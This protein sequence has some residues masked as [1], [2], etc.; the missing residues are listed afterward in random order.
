MAFKQY[1]SPGQ[2]KPR[3]AQDTTQN[4]KQRQQSIK[5]GLDAVN[6]QQQSNMTGV[7]NVTTASQ[8]L[9]NQ[10]R[11]N[12]FNAETKNKQAIR[13]GYVQNFQT[14][15]NNIAI[16]NKETLQTMEMIS[17]LSNTAFKYGKQFVEEREKGMRTA[18]AQA[19]YQ[20][21][22]TAQ[23]AIEITKLDTLQSSDIVNQNLTVQKLLDRGVSMQ[24][25][26]YI[27]NVGGGGGNRYLE[28]KALLQNTLANAPTRLEEL[29][30]KQYNVGGKQVSYNDAYAAG[31]ARLA[32]QLKGMINNEY[33]ATSGLSE[34]NPQLVGTEVYPGIRQY[35]KRSDAALS[36]QV[37]TV[38]KQ[39]SEEKLMANFSTARDYRQAWSYVKAS[40]DKRGARKSYLQWANN[41]MLAK[42]E[43]ADQI[44]K[45][46]STLKGANGQPA[47]GPGGLYN[48]DPEYATLLKQA[49]SSKNYVRSQ[50]RNALEDLKYNQDVAIQQGREVLAA[51]AADGSLNDNEV[52]AV[53]ETL[54]EQGYKIPDSLFEEYTTVED[55]VQ[56]ENTKQATALAEAGLLTNE[57]LSQFDW[58][59]RQSFQSTADAT[60]KL[61]ATTNDF[62]TV[63]SEIDRAVRGAVNAAPDGTNN[64]TVGP[65]QAKL[66]REAR[67]AALA[68]LATNPNMGQAALEKYIRD[69]VLN[70]FLEKVNDPKQRPSIIGNDNKN[71]GM[72]LEFIPGT[73]DGQE[74]IQKR[75]GYITEQLKTNP[76]QALTKE[77][78]LFTPDEAGRLKGEFGTP[79]FKIPWSATYAA[80]LLPNTSPYEVFMAQMKANGAEIKPTGSME[81]SQEIDADIKAL[82]DKF[83]TPE[84]S[85]RGIGSTNNFNPDFIPNNMGPVIEQAAQVSGA[86][87]AEL[88]ALF[89]IESGFI[90]D[91]VSYNGSSFGIAQ[92]HK[93]S[94]PVFFSGAD[95]KDPQANASYG[96][97]YYQ[98][99]VN[100]YKDPVAAAMAY[101]AGPGN[102]DAYLAGTLPD[103]PIKTEMLAH[104]EKFSKA[105]YKYG[106]TSQLSNPATMRRSF[107]GAL[108]YKDNRES[109]ISAGKEFENLGFRVGEQSDFDPV[110][111]THASNSYHNFDEA[112]DI[113]HWQGTRLDSIEKTRQLKEAIRSLGLFE[114]IIGP[115]DGD[116]DHESHLHVGGL[117]RP[118][119]EQDRQTL[120]QLFN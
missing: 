66:K 117:M 59:T 54:R 87:P 33:I 45:D 34:F 79:G 48:G 18:Y 55:A 106:D 81:A 50:R 99:L 73:A 16:E 63:D 28:S 23:E 47:F 71:K 17:D 6:Q 77:N 96:A 20:S 10:N 56:A 12:V 103:G 78:F 119:T 68:A 4:L 24:T 93:A 109:Y 40:A 116:P 114:E 85:T 110:D 61:G 52:E 46:L 107:T 5:A 51:K 111:G 30:E 67:T 101:N 97:Q 19:V 82:M 60:D 72:F 91:R 76:Q 21:G 43:N 95:W 13:E 8:S 37:S 49:R 80:S 83:N 69:T 58:K 11:T 74:R 14:E 31:N 94:H 38:A 86:Q 57:A 92:L 105:L 115:G 120:R 89:E 44:L 42:P 98:S 7:R 3:R 64:Y 53:R 88:A 15:T 112:F 62:K 41:Q 36:T 113:T 70:P 35:W 1:G 32:N 102:Y 108:T 104:G 27:R 29:K 25:L 65:M 39:E 90:A 2:F 118:M 9:E 100:Q 84:I 75:A 26:E 22:I